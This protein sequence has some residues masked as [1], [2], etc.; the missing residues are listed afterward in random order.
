M[1]Q[2]LNIIQ[3]VP[4]NVMSHEYC[5]HHSPLTPNIVIKGKKLSFGNTSILN[6][7]FIV[8]ANLFQKGLK[9]MFCTM[10]QLLG[11]LSFGLEEDHRRKA[12]LL[13]RS[14]EESR[15]LNLNQG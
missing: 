13:V 14:L 15:S 7:Y 12:W 8:S 3:E 11:I 5:M 10:L 2:L 6:L 9:L 4:V 1:I